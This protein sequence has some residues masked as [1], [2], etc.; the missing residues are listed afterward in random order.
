MY[1]LFV[2]TYDYHHWNDFVIASDDKQNL[3]DYCVKYDYNY[4][5][6]TDAE[7]ADQRKEIH[8]TIEEIDCI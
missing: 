8:Y 6:G 3:V 4:L 1:G 7:K 5:E 2:N